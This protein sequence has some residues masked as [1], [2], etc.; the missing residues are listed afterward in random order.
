LFRNECQLGSERW[1]PSRSVHLETG[2][3]SSQPSG[4][5]LVA[6]V[7]LDAEESLRRPVPALQLGA[8]IADDSVA[9]TLVVAVADGRDRFAIG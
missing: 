1:T 9:D 3:N 2:K 7:V 4:T 6:A 8:C 5:R